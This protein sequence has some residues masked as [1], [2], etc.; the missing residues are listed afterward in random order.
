M[1]NMNLDSSQILSVF[2]SNK[3][4][5]IESFGESLLLVTSTE[6]A[7]NVKNK[8]TTP[9]L[10]VRDYPVV[11]GKTYTFV[12]SGFGNVASSHV[13]LYVAVDERDIVDRTHFLPT[14]TDYDPD[15]NDRAE[16][17]FTATKDHVD[18]G[19]LIESATVGDYFKVS[20]IELYETHASFVLSD[21]AD[22]EGTLRLCNLF[23]TDM[24]STDPREVSR[25]DISVISKEGKNIIPDLQHIQSGSV[26]KFTNSKGEYF[27]L[28]VKGENV[29]EA[30]DYRGFNAHVN[31]FWGDYPSVNQLIFYKGSATAYN[32]SNDTDD[33]AFD[34]YNIRSNV[35][36]MVNL[37]GKKLN[38]P[39]AMDAIWRFF[40]A[41]VDNVLFNGEEEVN[42]ANVIKTRFYANIDSLRSAVGQDL[43][44][45]FIFSDGWGIYPDV[46]PN[47]TD[48]DVDI[49]MVSD[50][51]Y[52]YRI[53]DPASGFSVSDVLTIV[54]DEFDG[55]FISDNDVTLT[56][57][58]VDENGAIL[59]LNVS[60]TPPSKAWEDDFIEDGGEDQYDGGNFLYTNL[61]EGS[62]PYND[63][64]VSSDTSIFG[65]GS[66]YVVCYDKSI[67]ACVGVN[68]SS[69]VD[70]VWYEGE[71]GA[72]GN[73]TKKIDQ[74][75]A[76][77]LMLYDVSCVDFT[78]GLTFKIDGEE[79]WSLE[80]FPFPAPE[81]IVKYYEVGQD[82]FDEPSDDL[83]HIDLTKS[84]HVLQA[85]DEIYSY[86]YLPDGL[87][88][89]QTLKFVA[90]NRWGIEHEEYP[91][92]SY[93]TIEVDNLRN[94]D[95]E[96][97]SNQPW[98]PFSDR[99]SFNSGVAFAVW[100]DGAW[101]I[102]PNYWD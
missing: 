81:G 7:S 50:H 79:R 89:G 63:G 55:G 49:G 31:R 61:S 92:S 102:S 44:E 45:G 76:S 13:F 68:V 52:V 85:Y 34:V 84:V 15:E 60:G 70:E 91:T 19:V 42:D 9:G 97:Y 74:V 20:R 14:E 80:I 32:F 23:D 8:K 38:Q 71:M 67:F 65:T 24:L 96:N 77:N 1:L 51:Y 100:T 39:L 69:D 86:Y 43:Y 16:V 26:L 33:D 46:S 78:A 94:A 73:G 75:Y 93:V 83:E 25:I 48:V 99:S 37:Y 27:K 64:L 82:G 36:A 54:G 101:T 35:I 3:D 22:I 28:Q 40:R 6:S 53:R 29:Y 59:G 98:Y 87:Y 58:R 18:L 57:T 88:D 5:T 41:F 30:N 66:S 56:V 72:D 62:I 17:T 2:A 12:V 11:S 95:G 47:E 90:G 10:L 21:S 4:A